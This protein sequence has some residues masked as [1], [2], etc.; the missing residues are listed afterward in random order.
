MM[1][2][3]LCKL[4]VI[5]CGTVIN[6]KN[7]VKCKF[8]C[9]IGG[10]KVCNIDIKLWIFSLYVSVCNLEL[11]HWHCLTAVGNHLSFQEFQV[12]CGE[13]SPIQSTG[14]GR[15]ARRVAVMSS[16]WCLLDIVTTCAHQSTGGGDQREESQLCLAFGVCWTLSRLALTSPRE[17]KDQRE[18]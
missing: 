1:W 3:K 14:G 5:C 9:K 18:E 15:P 17:G 7:V 10:T 11:V 13:R 4:V 2:K 16:I 6:V 12:P 8:A